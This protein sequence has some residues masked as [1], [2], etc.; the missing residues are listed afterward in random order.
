M[1]ESR[2]TRWT[3]RASDV[4][5]L[6]PRR[7]RRRATRHLGSRGGARR[8]KAEMHR[9]LASNKHS[10]CSDGPSSTLFAAICFSGVGERMAGWKVSM[11]V[12]RL[13][14]VVLEIVKVLVQFEQELK[15]QELEILEG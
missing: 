8:S 3:A 12:V 11:L 15:A 1:K 13:A 4:G 6:V 14:L 5:Y 2:R 10:P 9:N 7:T